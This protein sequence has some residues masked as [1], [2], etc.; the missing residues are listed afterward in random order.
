MIKMSYIDLSYAVM[1]KTSKVSMLQIYCIQAAQASQI[2]GFFHG[3][4]ALEG[5]DHRMVLSIKHRN[6]MTLAHFLT[7]YFLYSVS[8]YGKM[9]FIILYFAVESIPGLLSL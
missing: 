4:G 1:S 7:N 5:T 2:R 3:K 8:P 6:P 9:I